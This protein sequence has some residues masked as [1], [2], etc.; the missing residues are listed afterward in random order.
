MK[1]KTDGNG[2]WKIS[3]EF[4]QRLNRLEPNDTV[5]AIVLLD[6]RNDT[7]SGGRRQS[8]TQREASIDAV[9]DSA[10][11]AL[12]D[13]DAILKRAGGR[14]LADDPDALGTIPVES[15]VAGINALADSDWVTA[16]FED[17]S[18]LPAF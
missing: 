1:H 4:A 8:L 15:T 13:I 3:P 16:I 11:R 5:C 12:V 17:Q 14:R 2:S 6:A 10:E 18:V 9:R 7:G